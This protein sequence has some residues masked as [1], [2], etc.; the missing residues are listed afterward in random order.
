SLL[1]GNRG[2][3]K[4]GRQLVLIDVNRWLGTESNRRNKDFLSFVLPTE[5]PGRYI[6]VQFVWRSKRHT[7]PRGL[8]HC[9]RFARPTP[10]TRLG[11]SSE[12]NGGP[13][14]TRTC[15]RSVMSR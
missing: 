3:K 11:Y 9:M 4:T 1:P 14:R 7:N 10:S 8:Q 5:L 6:I 12:F 15:D 2:L 13:C